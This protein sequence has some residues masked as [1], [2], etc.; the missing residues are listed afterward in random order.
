MTSDSTSKDRLKQA[1]PPELLNVTLTPPPGDKELQIPFSKVPQQDHSRDA[2]ESMVVD[3]AVDPSVGP[4]Q[5]ISRTDSE[6]V[7]VNMSAEEEPST[8][9]TT[10]S[11]EISIV[12]SQE[13]NELTPPPEEVATTEAAIPVIIT[14]SDQSTL[15]SGKA[16]RQ[17]APPKVKAPKATKSRR[18]TSKKQAPNK[19]A[20]VDSSEVTEEQESMEETPLAAC[21]QDPSQI[22][23]PA[24]PDDEPSSSSQLPETQLGEGTFSSYF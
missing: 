12:E 8:S 23:S 22:Q 15:K 11:S 19:R 18:S 13:E 4:T 3:T 1:I 21:S 9:S 10:R 20:K 6:L 17:K 16:I 2:S 7:N 24:L 14:S 5:S